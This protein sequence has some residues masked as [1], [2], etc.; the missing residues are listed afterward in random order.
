MINE[1]KGFRKQIDLIDNQIVYLLAKRMKVVKKIGRLKK[2][3]NIPVLDKS[4]WQKVIRSKKGY[5]KKIWE[6]IHQEALKV[7]L[8]CASKKSL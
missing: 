8:A 6:I 5:V 7:E 3:N 2:E 1:L 4:R